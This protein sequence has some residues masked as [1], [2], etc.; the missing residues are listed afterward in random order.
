MTFRR[1]SSDDGIAVLGRLLA[2]V[3]VIAVLGVL[4]AT[5][6]PALAASDVPA[7]GVQSSCHAAGIDRASASVVTSPAIECE[8]PV[9][10]A[11]DVTACAMS[12]CMTVP[13]PAPVSVVG[14]H[15]I[16]L[17]ISF[18]GSGQPAVGIGV[19]PGLRPP[20]PATGA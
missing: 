5:L 17:R 12:A 16:I 7:P 10:I 13:L 15:D 19:S 18:G 1:V 20:I 11:C 14:Q 3:R 8:D 9:G 2:C 4:L 6:A